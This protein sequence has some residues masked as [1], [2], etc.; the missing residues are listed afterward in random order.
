MSNALAIAAVSAILRDLMESALGGGKVGKPAIVAISSPDQINMDNEKDPLLNLFLYNVMPNPGWR[1]VGLP[2]RDLHGGWL[3]N[4]PLAIDLY[5]MLTAY[6]KDDYQA[7]IMLGYAMQALHENPVLP[8]EDIRKFF[9]KNLPLPEKLKPLANSDLADQLELIKITP[10]QLSTEE[11]SKLWT[12][13]SAHYRPSVAYHVSVVLIEGKKPAKSPLPVL[14]RGP[15]DKLT[16]REGGVTSQPSLRPQYPTLVEAKPPNQQIAVRMGDELTLLGYQLEGTAVTVLFTHLPSMRKLELPAIKGSSSSDQIK[17]KIPA[18]PPPAILPSPDDDPDKWAIGIYRVA[19][20]INK[21]GKTENVVT[22]EL[23][24]LLAP[25]IVRQKLNP[26]PP[27]P[28]PQDEL[29]HFEKDGA[30]NVTKFVVI[31]SPKVWK[32]QT[33][34]LI[35]GSFE[36]AADPIPAKSNN[37]DFEIKPSKNLSGANQPVRL[38]VDGVESILIDRNKSPPEFD[39]SQRMDIP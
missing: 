12:A 14:T 33:A 16:G 34:K 17:V 11:I 10:H 1:N 4:P 8:R 13:F 20:T 24:I 27:P 5:Y 32:G 26:P 35:V 21:Q 31:C 28:A 18:D 2:S 38:Q 22:N 37:I 15:P 25:R 29:I 36:I 9:T 3:S 6:G 7:E 39:D 30:G 19:A 23:S